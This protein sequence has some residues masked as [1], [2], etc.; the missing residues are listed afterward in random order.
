MEHLGRETSTDLCQTDCFVHRPHAC[1]DVGDVSDCL[2]GDDIYIHAHSLQELLSRIKQSVGARCDV[3]SIPL[4]G[5]KKERDL[6]AKAQLT[7]LEYLD[8]GMSKTVSLGPRADIKDSGL[9]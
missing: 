4:I 5:Q 9:D 6:H 3:S 2:V 1:R 7:Q 8:F